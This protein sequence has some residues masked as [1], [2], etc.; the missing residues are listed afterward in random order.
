MPR[1][2]ACLAWSYQ[3]L[4]RNVVPERSYFYINGFGVRRRDAEWIGSDKKLRNGGLSNSTGSENREYRSPVTDKVK[5]ALRVTAN[6]R[7]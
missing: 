2:A 1:Y 7:R 3:Y 5:Q 6:Q 4:A